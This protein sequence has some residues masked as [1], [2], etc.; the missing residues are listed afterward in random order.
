[1]KQLASLL[2]V[3]A[4]LAGFALAPAASAGSGCAYNGG[5]AG[6]GCPP[7]WCDPYGCLQPW[8]YDNPLIHGPRNWSWIYP[9]GGF[10]AY[11][12]EPGSG[13]WARSD[14]SHVNWVVSPADNA[15]GVLRK[16][17]ALG[18]PRVPQDT[19]YLGKNP[20]MVDK[21]KLPIPRAWQPEPEKLKEPEKEVEKDKK[22]K[23]GK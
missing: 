5:C 9:D 16:L 7:Y 12:G 23:D 2:L 20:A 18:I 4:V 19:I 8:P 1:M 3:S 13:V 11:P 6:D 17:D 22:E 10:T 15:Q 14:Y 21:A